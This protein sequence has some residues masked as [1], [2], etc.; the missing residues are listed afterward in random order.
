MTGRIELRD[1]RALG[2][3]G[4]LEEERARA[5]PFSIDVDAWLDVDAASLSDDLADTADYGAIA[6]RAA[7]VVSARSFSLLEALAAAVAG[8][9]LATDARIERVEVTVRKL[10]PP[11]DTDLGTAAVRVSR[12]RRD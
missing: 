8:E 4:V 5:Q 1:L 2:V 10:R 11:V 6:S 9:V 3:H 12:G 7:Q